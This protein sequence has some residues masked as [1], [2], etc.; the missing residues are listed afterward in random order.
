MVHGAA[1]RAVS[2]AAAAGEK[3][4]ISTLRVAPQQPPSA[5]PTLAMLALASANAVIIG[6]ENW[7]SARVQSE[8]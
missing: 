1:G 3:R 7:R 2:S 6:P 5:C 4:P 8:L